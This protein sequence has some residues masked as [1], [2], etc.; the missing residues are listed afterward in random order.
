MAAS[1][2]HYAGEAADLVT[3]RA[4]IVTLAAGVAVAA[5]YLAGAA[6]SGRLSVLARQ[7]LL[8][9]LAPLPP[10]RW[11]EPPASL[12]S[13]NKPP[14]SGTSS[15]RIRAGKSEAGVFWTDDYQAAIVLS[16]GAIPSRRGQSSITLTLNP[17]PAGTVGPPPPGQ[18]F[19][20]NVYRIR[21]VYKPDGGTVRRLSVATAVVLMYPA[22]TG[23]GH[24]ALL[25]STDGK[26]WRALPTADS[27]PQQQ[28]ASQD[29]HQL[30]YFV[31]SI[32]AANGEPGSGATWLVVVIVATA[33]V[34]VLGLAWFE[35]RRG[36]AANRGTGGDGRV[37]RGPPRGN[38][39]TEP[40][41]RQ[42]Y[43]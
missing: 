27:P 5:A 15:V 14:L 36:R 4:R 38:D 19:N 17:I 7:P 24:H 16:K 6:L 33:I 8:D 40:P 1:T 12:R 29:V 31:V 3:I 32:N 30:G 25:Q 35:I 20:G 42:P 21:G 11:L 28:V 18:R 39:A 43:E 41:P 37:E 23:S 10:Y 22:H 26:A 34:A 13:T 2:R 9:G